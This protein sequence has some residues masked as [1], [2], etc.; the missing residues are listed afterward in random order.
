MSLRLTDKLIQRQI[1]HW[2]GLRRYLREADDAP[3][4]AAPPGPVIT[5]SR[6]AGSGG[7]ELAHALCDRLGL[8]LHDRSLVEDVVRRRKLPADLVA[9]LD[10]QDLR[11][12]D[13]WVRGVLEQR[14]FL[15][16]Q[17]RQALTEIVDEIAAVGG[18]VFLGRGAHLV[19]GR[20]ATLRVRLVGS[21]NERCGRL[22][23]AHG[24]S[25]PE[26]RALMAETDRRRTEFINKL[27][28]P[29]AETP[30]A[31]DLVLNT[32][33]LAVNSAVEIVLLALLES[34]DRVRSQTVHA[35]G[36]D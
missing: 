15:V 30:T 2:N 29:D 36:A 9:R 1:N 22:R 33:R 13:L 4:G 17:Y 16:E 20:R 25:R 31:Y 26:A 27:F 6:Q 7:R 21:P 5:V 24:W 12:S 10:E 19:L 35:A 8:Q 28:G 11:Q 34:Q 3:A 23:D 14:L 18:A 32:D